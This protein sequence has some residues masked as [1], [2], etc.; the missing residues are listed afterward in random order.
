M[1]KFSQDFSTIFDLSPILPKKLQ[2]RK[3][4][5]RKVVKKW[6]PMMDIA[7]A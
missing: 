6:Q 3:K 4:N 2:K 7:S 1:Q 5:P